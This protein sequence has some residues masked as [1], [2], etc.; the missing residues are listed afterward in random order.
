MFYFYAI[1]SIFCLTSVLYGSENFM[2]FDDTQLPLQPEETLYHKRIYI[3]NQTSYKIRVNLYLPADIE[4]HGESLT[5]YSDSTRI[6]EPYSAAFLLLKSHRTSAD[7]NGNII[8]RVDYIYNVEEK[9]SA[10]IWADPRTIPTTILSTRH[11]I[12]PEGKDLTTLD[13]IKYSVVINEKN[14]LEIKRAQ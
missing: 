13:S 12:Y 8:S 9:L 14:K 2:P 1:C 7:K 5:E 4:D 11:T 3:G 6:I 10:S